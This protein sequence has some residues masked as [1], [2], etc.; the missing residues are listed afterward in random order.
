LRSPPQN[1][2]PPSFSQFNRLLIP[3]AIIGLITYAWLWIGYNWNQE[4]ALL[5]ALDFKKQLPSLTGYP[6][7]GYRGALFLLVLAAFAATWWPNDKFSVT[8]RSSR[9]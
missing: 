9:I 4:Q 2:L 6:P 8:L 7:F 3:V 5:E 1:L